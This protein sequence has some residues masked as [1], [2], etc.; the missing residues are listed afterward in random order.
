LLFSEHL[1]EKTEESRHNETVGY[2]TITIGSVFFVAGLLET[3]ITAEN[4]EWFLMIPYHITPHPYSLLGM[5]L[6]SVG[7]VLIIVGTALAL[8]YARQRSWYMK[9]LQKARTFEAQRLKIDK[10][11]EKDKITPHRRKKASP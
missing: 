9:E 7:I 6:T 2:L 5:S 11:L 10:K 8:H 4:P 1:H 3:V